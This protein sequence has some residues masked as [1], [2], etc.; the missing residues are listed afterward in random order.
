MKHSRL[1]DDTTFSVDV[2]EELL[3]KEWAECKE[4]KVSESTL[5][6]ED[7]FDAEKYLTEIER[8]P[9]ECQYEELKGHFENSTR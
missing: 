7:E 4:E 8:L 6:L 3:E 1:S 2:L 5:I 9:E